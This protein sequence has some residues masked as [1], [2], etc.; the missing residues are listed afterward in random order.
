MRGREMKDKVIMET[1]NR[2]MRDRE[3]MGRETKDRDKR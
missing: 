3:V 1:R 2:K